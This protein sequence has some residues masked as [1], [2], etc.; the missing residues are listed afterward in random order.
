MKPVFYVYC[1]ET[2]YTNYKHSTQESAECEAE[3]L[4]RKHPGIRFQVLSVI[5]ECRM[6]DIIW[7]KVQ[8]DDILF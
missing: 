2:R 1:P 5:G 8:P 3:R 6:T 4:A 7:D